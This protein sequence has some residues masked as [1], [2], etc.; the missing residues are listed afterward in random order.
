MIGSARIR[1]F[2]VLYLPSWATD[3]LKRAEPNLTGPL[4]LYE[5]V[6]GGLRIAALDRE[7][8]QLGIRQGQTLADAR[9]LVPTLIVR[10]MDR[11]WFEAGFADFADWHSNASPLVAVMQDPSK[12]GDLVLDTTGVD[13]LFGGEPNMLRTLLTR[14][15]ALG[16]T[17][18]GS[19]APTIGAAWGVSHYARSQIV[20]PD[21]LDKVLDTLPV[22]AL[23][24]DQKQLATL[25][26]MGLKT[27]GELRTRPRKPLQARFGQSLILRLDQ[28]YG[29]VLE[30]MNPRLPQTEQF[31]ERRFA[32]PIA[33]IDDVLATTKDLAITLSQQLEKQGQG[34]QSFHLF[35]YRVDHKVM[36]LSV[37]SARVTRDPHH[38]SQLFVHRAERFSAE[39]DPGFGIDMVRLSASSLDHLGETQ[40]SAFS[41]E[42]GT[43]DLDQL[44]DRLASRLGVLSVVR[45]QLLPSHMP[46][47]AARLVPVQACQTFDRPD[48]WPEMTRPL[49]LL[50]S[51]E[52]ID[53]S[54]EVPDGLPALMVWRRLHYR[55][56]KGA[57]PERL[58][59]E[60]WRAPERLQLAPE[61]HPT[62]QA[63]EEAQ[64]TLPYSSPLPLFVPDD[65]TRD[66]YSVEDEVGRRFWVFRQGFYGG[67]THPTWYLHGLFA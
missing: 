56:V 8:A 67:H 43:Q 54:A 49:R 52:R 40:A 48:N 19:I 44:N 51:P 3:Y 28:A 57:G 33:L 65:A 4:A 53:I 39:Y 42:D 24:L 55:L 31:A 50:P 14:L 26:Q 11:D 58:G 22:A 12:F 66:Y 7:A 63:E 37:N 20:S 21:T 16:Y 59:A 10:E 18:A 29:H 1:R 41:L 32:E 27:I 46:E 60:W 15:R 25:A 2:L 6:Q 13:H 64:L 9:A 61:T 34:A 23:R 47:R 35:L 36:T 5:R 17:V 38:I 62:E 30:R 45:T